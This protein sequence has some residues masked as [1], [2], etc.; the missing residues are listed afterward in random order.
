MCAREYRNQ[1]MVRRIVHIY[2]SSPQWVSN[3]PGKRAVIEN[4]TLRTGGVVA[5]DS[6]RFWLFPGRDF[7]FVSLESTAGTV[8]SFNSSVNSSKCGSG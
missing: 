1:N 8:V 2:F 3:L 7:N 4:C 5:Y 6:R